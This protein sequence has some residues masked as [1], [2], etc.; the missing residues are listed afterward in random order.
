MFSLVKDELG[1]VLIAPVAVVGGVINSS[2]DLMNHVVMS[3]LSL[4]MI[5]LGLLQCGAKLRTR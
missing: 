4:T 5:L 1:F 3:S 2:G